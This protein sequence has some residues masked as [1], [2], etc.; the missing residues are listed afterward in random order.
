MTRLKD[1]DECARV[2]SQMKILVRRNYSSPP[3][4]GSRIVA[5]LLSDPALK[6]MWLKDVKEMADRCAILFNSTGILSQIR[7]KLRDWAVWQARA[8]RLLLSGSIVLK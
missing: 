3:I 1:K 2:T 5:E 4:N 6:A 8:G 7:T